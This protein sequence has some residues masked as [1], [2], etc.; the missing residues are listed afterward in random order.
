MLIGADRFVDDLEP[1]QQ[2][3]HATQRYQRGYS[4]IDMWNFDGFLADVIVAGCN[5]MIN[6]AMTTPTV[7][8]DEEDWHAILVEIRDGFSSRQDNAPTPPDSAWELLRKYFNYM[9][10]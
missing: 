6:E 4:D 5:W 8:D 3:T 2:A 9:W 10:D 1:L 7:I